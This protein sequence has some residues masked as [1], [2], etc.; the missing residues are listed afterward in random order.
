MKLNAQITLDK[1]TESQVIQELQTFL[2]S[3]NMS[4]YCLPGVKPIRSEF[5]D[6]SDGTVEIRILDYEFSLDDL[7]TAESESKE[8]IDTFDDDI[9]NLLKGLN[10]TW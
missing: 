8:L 9:K 4:T 10:P 5:C 7:K 1:E 3:Y 2:T 6:N